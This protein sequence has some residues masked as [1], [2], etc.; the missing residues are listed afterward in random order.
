MSEYNNVISILY[1]ESYTIFIFIIFIECY[2]IDDM[3]RC[4]ISS[5]VHM[6]CLIESRSSNYY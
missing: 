3:L 4:L 5:S 2:K 1:I 6:G